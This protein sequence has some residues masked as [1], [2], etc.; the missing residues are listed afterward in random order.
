MLNLS[1][2][3]WTESSP[4][5]PSRESFKMNPCGVVIQRI[6]GSKLHNDTG[7]AKPE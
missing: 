5:T 4:T 2:Y 3:P 1:H 7:A 6:D